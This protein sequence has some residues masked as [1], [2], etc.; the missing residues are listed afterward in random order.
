MAYKSCLTIRYELHR[1]LGTE[2]ISGK[3][4]NSKVSQRGAQCSCQNENFAST[5]RKL[6]KKEIKLFLWCSISHEN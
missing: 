3:C 5:S 1:T 6:L 2:K 4:L